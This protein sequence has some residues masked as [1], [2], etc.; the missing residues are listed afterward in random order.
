MW[1]RVVLS[2]LAMALVACS[3]EPV[4]EP[5][6]VIPRTQ[7]QAL[8]RAKAVEQDVKQQQESLR[9]SVGAPQ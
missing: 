3:S 5:K 4:E 2:G 7:V 1:V 6:G 9:N 8:N